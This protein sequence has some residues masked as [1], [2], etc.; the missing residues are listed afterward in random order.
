MLLLSLWA[1]AAAAAATA[2][3]SQFELQPFAAAVLTMKSDDSNAP[4]RRGAPRWTPGDAGR[5]A[6][7]IGFDHYPFCNASLDINSRVLP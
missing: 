6:C 2:A 3:G 4:L 5:S 1:D 7:G